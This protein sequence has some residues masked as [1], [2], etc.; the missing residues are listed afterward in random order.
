M[1]EKIELAIYGGPINVFYKKK[2]IL[3]HISLRIEK[4]KITSIIGQSGCGKSTSTKNH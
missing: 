2:Q 1:A 4:N 3:H